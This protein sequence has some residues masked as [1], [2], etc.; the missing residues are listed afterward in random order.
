M[1]NPKYII[2]QHVI[3]IF[4]P[5]VDHAQFA[6]RNR[7]DKEDIQGAG[8]ICFSH[9]ELDCYGKSISLGIESLIKEDSA[10]ANNS[11]VY[12]GV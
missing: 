3:Y 1:N 10:I 2:Y 6:Q 12:E 9:T 11:F 7:F 4:P 8:F 5:F